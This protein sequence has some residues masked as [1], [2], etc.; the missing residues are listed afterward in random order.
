MIVKTLHKTAWLTGGVIFLLLTVI[1]L[2]LPVIPQLPFFLV[3]LF[4]FMR[5]STRFDAWVRRQ[6]WAHR[7]KERLHHRKADRD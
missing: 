2:L 3:C 1:G 6:H 5:C 4:C 7:L